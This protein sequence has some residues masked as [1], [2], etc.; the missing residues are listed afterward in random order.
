MHGGVSTGTHGSSVAIGY[1]SPNSGV[2]TYK[3]GTLVID[4]ID[5]SS[6]KI[7]WRGVAEGRLPKTTSINERTQIV[8]D[9]VGMVF[10][11]F[12]PY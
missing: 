2:R 9:A 5:S 11:E 7:V 4:I 12:P 3:E 6:Y 10:E 1:S 8:R